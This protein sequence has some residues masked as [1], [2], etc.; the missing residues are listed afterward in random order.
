MTELTEKLINRLGLD[1][2][3]SDDQCAGVIR[4]IDKLSLYK[5]SLGIHTNYVAAV[6]ELST[7]RPAWVKQAKIVC[8]ERSLRKLYEI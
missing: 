3:N 7:D 8:N 6:R 4:A 2:L 5:F 1:G